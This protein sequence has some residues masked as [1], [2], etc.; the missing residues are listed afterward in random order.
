ML[1]L[2]DILLETDRSIERR[3]AVIRDFKDVLAFKEPEK[4]TSRRAVAAL[5]PRSVDDEVLRGWLDAQNLTLSSWNTE[6]A[7]SVSL[8]V[9][10]NIELF[11]KL[12]ES[13]QYIKKRLQQKA[14]QTPSAL[15][16]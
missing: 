2:H 12:V 6:D 14:E 16:E 5:F 10:E 3:I 4:R 1:E 13:S 9:C 8:I 11:P 7:E 15:S